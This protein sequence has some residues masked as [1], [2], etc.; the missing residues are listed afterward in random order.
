MTSLMMNLADSYTRPWKRWRDRAYEVKKK[1]I[2]IAM[3]AIGNRLVHLHTI[4][5]GIGENYNSVDEFLSVVQFCQQQ[6][7]TMY[8]FVFSKFTN[9]YPAL[10]QQNVLCRLIKGEY[11]LMELCAVLKTAEKELI[12]SNG[13]I[14]L[15]VLY[16]SPASYKVHIGAHFIK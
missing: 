1:A 3:S 4:T 13:L 2:D 11:S 7:Q 8:D 16:I 15:H 5:E 9:L 6:Y 14:K 10:K 12:K